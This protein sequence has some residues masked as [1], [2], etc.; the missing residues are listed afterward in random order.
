M[1]SEI[2]VFQQPEQKK[3]SLTKSE[4]ELLYEDLEKYSQID[5]HHF[6]AFYNM[7]TEDIESSIIDSTIVSIMFKYIVKHC[8]PIILEIPK[9]N[10]R[11]KRR[12]IRKNIEKKS[13]IKDYYFT[14]QF[15]HKTKGFTKSGVSVSLAPNIYYKIIGIK[16]P[17]VLKISQQKTIPDIGSVIN[18][19]NLTTMGSYGL[20]NPNTKRY[21]Q[22]RPHFIK[23]SHETSL[24]GKRIIFTSNEHSLK[25]VK[26]VIDNIRRMNDYY[27]TYYMSVYTSLKYKPFSEFRKIIIE[28]SVK[29]AAFDKSKVMKEM[30]ENAETT[31]I[32]EIYKGTLSKYSLRF[33]Y[34]L[35]NNNIFD[36]YNK[37]KLLGLGHDK[38]LG[39]LDD[40]VEKN[41][42]EDRIKLQR[43]QK[44][45]SYL[46]F[47]K[48]QAISFEKFQTR[49]LCDLTKNQKDILELEYETVKKLEKGVK[50]MSESL[51]IMWYLYR[52]LEDMDLKEIKIN[53]DKIRSL[54]E[55]IPENLEKQTELVKDVNG[56][57][58]V[59]PHVLIKAQ[60]IVDSDKDTQKL[61]Q[62]RDYLV[63]Y[64]SLPDN[65]SGHFCR[66][67]GGLIAERDEDT[68]VQFLNGAR[69]NFIPGVDKRQ[70]L[71]WKEVAH[72]LST[73]VKFKYVVN[74]KKIITSITTA[75]KGELGEIETKLAKIKTNNN[76]NL[77]DMLRV[78]I[79]IYT[80]AVLIHMIYLQYG[81]ITFINKDTR[82]GGDEQE[83]LPEKRDGIEVTGVD[84]CDSDSDEESPFL[85]YGGD[86]PKTKTGKKYEKAPKIEKKLLKEEDKKRLQ[87]IFRAA[88]E[89][90]I[91]SKSVLLNKLSNISIDSIKPLLIKAYQFIISLKQTVDVKDTLRQN[92]TAYFLSIDPVYEYIW[93]A[94]SLKS[95]SEKKGKLSLTDA[96]RYLG[97]TIGQ[98]EED[99]ELGKTIYETAKSVEPWGETKKAK[100]DHGS[101]MY[102]FEYTQGKLYNYDIIPQH[103]AIK[104]FIKRYAYL[105]K[106]VESITQDT[107]LRLLKP[108]INYEV[109]HGDDLVRKYNDFSSK[110]INIAEHY[111]S[112]GKRHEFSIFVFNKILQSGIL[113]TK[114][115]MEVTSK[116]VARWY[117]TEDKENIKKFKGY[118]YVDEKCANCKVYLS[119]NKK[120]STIADKIKEIDNLKAFYEYFENR[121]P[122]DN[123]H[124]YKIDAQKNIEN[125]TKCNFSRKLFDE[126]NKQYY[127]KYIKT[128]NEILKEKKKFDQ[129]SLKEFKELSKTYVVEI[130]KF[131]EWTVNNKPVLDLSR[132]RSVKY[133]ILVNLGLSEGRKFENIEKEKENPHINSSVEEDIV[134]NQYLRDYC[135]W[136]LRMYYNMRNYSVVYNIPMELKQIVE[137]NLGVGLGKLKDSLPEIYGDFNE[138]YVYYFRK[139]K[140]KLLANFLLNYLCSILMNIIESLQNTKFDNL[141]KEFVDYTISV[142]IKS[143]KDISKPPPLSLI[144]NKGS[145][146]EEEQVAGDEYYDAS[147]EEQDA[148]KS[149]EDLGDISEED[150]F[151][152]HNM[153]IDMSDIE[154]GDIDGNV[155]D[156]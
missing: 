1:S 58:M 86:G 143:E 127:E 70:T 14:M 101:F 34:S 51:K 129:E 36:I 100:Y 11:I 44:L 117:N 103:D 22:Q 57:S 83:D 126:L 25:V 114:D 124:D 93:Y 81:K 102:I 140:P 26:E 66:V 116:E 55:K 69:V 137:K 65:S 149:Y 74:L 150:D 35:Y 104:S 73:F 146:K 91:K 60:K 32:R 141:G 80:Y 15:S 108:S 31:K 139:L 68:I 135:L 123:L 5:S 119:N 79:T 142:I 133:N 13:E 72:I 54:A 28:N 105:D 21:T 78:Y 132:R 110:K 17:K 88:I 109:S 18:I 61:S 39:V 48:K 84:S 46:E 153:D 2:I 23:M 41:I 92:N 136:V 16:V 96:K 3:V 8:A 67:C 40:L 75:I 128:Y 50:K 155:Y 63:T 85:R 134:R 27:E 33:T 47:A 138:K 99:Y 94:H 7:E 53:L 20:Q 77:Q 6:D 98:I 89:M 112:D 24:S 152:R 43:K 121:C 56:V 29:P 156:Q 130:K 45:I 49:D 107:I 9:L 154:D 37:I 10:L 4:R 82:S 131:P 90:I 151:S 71:I 38:A 144:I 118:F 76:D 115:R 122:E 113:D 95:F 30:E 145:S 59:C 62:V 111:C 120:D 97:R 148:D 106:L 42:N 12:N 147:D 64:F 52:G 87:N 125:C 19:F